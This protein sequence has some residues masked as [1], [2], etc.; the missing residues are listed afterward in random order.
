MAAELKRDFG[1]GAKLVPGGHGAFDVIIDGKTVFSK[2]KTGRFP[3]PG[4]VAEEIRKRK[5]P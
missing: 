5:R 2:S 1:A 4:E 3:R